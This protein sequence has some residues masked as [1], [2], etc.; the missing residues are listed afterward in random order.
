MIRGVE[1]SECGLAQNLKI[2]FNAPPW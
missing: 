1:R 2:N